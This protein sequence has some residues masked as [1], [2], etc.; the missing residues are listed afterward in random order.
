MSNK[1]ESANELIAENIRLHEKIARSYDQRHNEIYNALE[2]ERLSKSLSEATDWIGSGGLRSMDYGCGAG[3]LTSHLVRLGHNVTAADVTP[4]FTKITTALDPAHITPFVLNGSDMHEIESNT[5]DLI[6][7]YSVLHH[8]PDYLSAIK[9]MIR[10]IKPGGIVYLD[11]EASPEHWKPSK[12]LSEFRSKTAVKPSISSYVVRLL[13]PKWWVKRVRKTINP[14]YAEEGDI[15]VWHDDH[16]E[17]DSIRKLLNNEGVEILRDE[18]YLL[19]QPHY[20]EQVWREYRNR[21]TDMHI[22]VGRKR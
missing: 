7:T 15:H 3:N 19:Y 13:S 4:S 18:S 14:R 8:I 11:H 5:F 12:A 9:E 22:V 16:I 1:Q 20:N 10:V 21:C 2:Q 6:A 17:W